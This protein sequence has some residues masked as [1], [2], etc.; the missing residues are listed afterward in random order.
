MNDFSGSDSSHPT[1]IEEGQ[2]IAKASEEVKASIHSLPTE[3]LIEILRLGLEAHD[4]SKSRHACLKDI[5][6]RVCRQW[7]DIVQQIP[8]LWTFVSMEMEDA[9]IVECLQRSGNHPLEVVVK[10]PIPTAHYRAGPERNEAWARERR[11]LQK[12][13][14]HIGRWRKASLSILGWRDVVQELLHS[15]APLLESLEFEWAGWNDYASHQIHIMQAQQENPFPQMLIPPIP[16]EELEMAGLAE[17][18]QG[19]EEMA[20]NLPA[21][22]NMPMWAD[23]GVEWNMEDEVEDEPPADEFEQQAAAIPV[24]ALFG[25]ETPRL[26]E[27]FIRGEAP[28]T[29]VQGILRNLETLEWTPAHKA[30]RGC[31]SLPGLLQTLTE[32]PEL[33]KLVIHEP[34]G[35]TAGLQGAP[36]QQGII[37]LNHLRHLS[38]GGMYPRGL[39]RVMDRLQIPDTCLLE[40]ADCTP[41]TMRTQ[42]QADLLAYLR[43]PAVSSLTGATRSRIAVSDEACEWIVEGLEGRRMHLSLPGGWKKSIPTLTWI[44]ELLNPSGVLE[45]SLELCLGPTDQHHEVTSPFYATVLQFNGITSLA[46]NISHWAQCSDLRYLLSTPVLST[47]TGART[48]PF[49]DVRSLTFGGETLSLRDVTEFVEAHL[50]DDQALEGCEKRPRA[51]ELVEYDAG[52]DIIEG[53]DLEELKKLINPGRFVRLYSENKST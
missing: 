38:V 10:H 25:G 20:A 8:S 15:P 17:D 43:H 49:P 37:H 40:V 5:L 16:F 7:R 35:S 11:F 19:A 24:P 30:G 21:L 50:G 39:I 13:V 41:F 27:A 14:P 1:A 44:R 34:Q 6:P 22:N 29:C 53:A 31:S 46:V 47:N 23:L 48:W 51:L 12:V 2:V 9:D 28:V 32:N 42:E 36:A 18:P 52:I 3:L 45:S 26:K 4:N 33:L